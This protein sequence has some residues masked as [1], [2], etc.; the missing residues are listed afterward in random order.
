MLSVVDRCES[1]VETRWSASASTC[2][3]SA[4]LGVE[5]PRVSASRRLLVAGKP[6]ALRSCTV[7]R[8]QLCCGHHTDTE[9]CKLLSTKLGWDEDG[10]S[11][12]ARKTGKASIRA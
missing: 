7:V 2:K 3:L 4:V 5:E 1:I 11:L 10:T 6:T 9:S 12:D 8:L